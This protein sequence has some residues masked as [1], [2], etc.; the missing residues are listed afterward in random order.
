[1]HLRSFHDIIIVHFH[2]KLTIENT[3]YEFLID[4]IIGLDDG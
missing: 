4:V 3:N 2:A 1:M